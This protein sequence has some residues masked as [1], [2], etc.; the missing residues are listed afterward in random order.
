[1]S[2]S[3]SVLALALGHLCMVVFSHHRCQTPKRTPFCPLRITGCQVISDLSSRPFDLSPRPKYFPKSQLNPD[4]AVGGGKL[5]RPARL[6]WGS[7]V[8]QGETCWRSPATGDE[9]THQ[10]Q[11]QTYR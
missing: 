1:M 11:T 5:K 10:R 2:Y 6:E 4:M 8:P 9:I 3:G 7:P